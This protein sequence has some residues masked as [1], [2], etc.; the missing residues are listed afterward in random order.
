MDFKNDVKKDL[1]FK[2]KDLGCK[3]FFIDLPI[4]IDLPNLV[5]HLSFIF[6]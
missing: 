6:L 2:A 1:G 4:F 3:E 5:A